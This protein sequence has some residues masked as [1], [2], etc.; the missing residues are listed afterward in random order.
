MIV[1]TGSCKSVR[2]WVSAPWQWRM[3]DVTLAVSLST[4]QYV[5][6]AVWGSDLRHNTMPLLC[7]RVPVLGGTR[8]RRYRSLVRLSI[9]TRGL[10]RWHSRMCRDSLHREDR[11][12]CPA[13]LSD[14]E[15]VGENTAP[16]SPPKILLVRTEGV[17]EDWLRN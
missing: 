3:S 14:P 15:T 7:C 8:E 1:L 6:N 5:S 16:R 10:L 9:T 4:C 2:R 13:L 17:V 12:Q 11:R